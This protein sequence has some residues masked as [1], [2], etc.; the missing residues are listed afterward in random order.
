MGNHTTAGAATVNLLDGRRVLLRPLRVED[1]DAVLVLHKNL[2]EDDRYLRFFTTRPG[3]LEQLARQLTEANT[4]ARPRTGPP[5]DRSPR[6]RRSDRV[7][8]DARR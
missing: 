6:R 2:P 7:R 4:G 3:H 1:A 8:P 5:P